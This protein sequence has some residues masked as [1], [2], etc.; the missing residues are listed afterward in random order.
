MMRII[1]DHRIRKLLSGFIN[2]SSA[3]NPSDPSS[4]RDLG[5]QLNAIVNIYIEGLPEGK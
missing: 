2:D 5:K 3:T 4:M 1:Q